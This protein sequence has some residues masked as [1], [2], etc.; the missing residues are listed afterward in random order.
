MEH[1]L[2]RGTVRDKAGKVD[3]RSQRPYLIDKHAKG[4][5]RVL[6]KGVRVGE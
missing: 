6:N 1:K 3:I 4:L 2:G 5:L